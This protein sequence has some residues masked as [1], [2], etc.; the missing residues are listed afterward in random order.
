LKEQI[1]KRAKLNLPPDHP[2]VIERVLARIDAM[3]PE[4]LEVMLSWRPEGVE[5]TNMNETL[6]QY[7]RERREK[8]AQSKVV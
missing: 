3:T 4:E 7:D 8:E 1:M 2:L 5:I 6:K